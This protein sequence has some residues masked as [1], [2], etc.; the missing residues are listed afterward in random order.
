M[1]DSVKWHH[2]CGISKIQMVR[3]RTQN[4]VLSTNNHQGEKKKKERGRAYRLKK[5]ETY[6]MCGFCLDLDFNKAPSPNSMRLLGKFKHLWVIQ[7]SLL[8]FEI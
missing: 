3:N 1:G 7:E 5:T 4:F 2:V 6:A 8:T